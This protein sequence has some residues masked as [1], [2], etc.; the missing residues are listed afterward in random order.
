MNKIIAVSDIV[1]PQAQDAS[2]SDPVWPAAVFQQ[3][4][5]I[6]NSNFSQV[7]V[8]GGQKQIG[9][10]AAARSITAWFVAG[11]RIDAGAPGLS[12]DVR[13]QF[14]QLPEIR[15]IIQPITL[16]A[17]GN[18]ESVRHRRAFDFRFCDRNTS[19]SGAGGLFAATVARSCGDRRRR[20]RSHGHSRQAARREAWWEQSGYCGA[21]A[22]RASWIA[23]CDYGDES[24]DGDIGFSRETHFGAEGGCDGDRGP[25]GWSAGAV[26]FSVDGES[27]GRS[28][29][30]TAE[31]RFRAGSRADVGRDSIPRSCFSRQVRFRASYRSRTRTI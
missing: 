18:A 11:I 5:G 26:D 27:A 30:D 25:S 1:S 10:P 6:A 12:N 31:R 8:V 15:L 29:T 7:A 4:V 28:G 16:A 24:A 13:G 14:G 2:K 9:L 23:G 3:F 22:R 19:G 20:Q 17:D 21:A